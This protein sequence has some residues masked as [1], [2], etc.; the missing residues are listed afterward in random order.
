MRE[1]SGGAASEALN[2]GR[3]DNGARR[4]PEE[5]SASRG[6]A[7]A[8]VAQ[9]LS[10]LMQQTPTSSIGDRPIPVDVEHEL[11]TLQALLDGTPTEAEY[12]LPVLQQVQRQ[13]G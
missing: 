10:P 3:R 7:V 2:D 11:A 5:I 12:L 9:S 6:V 1:T 13:F 8:P 4:T